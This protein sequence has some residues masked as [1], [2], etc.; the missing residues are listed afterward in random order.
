MERIICPRRR[1]CKCILFPHSLV[2]CNS[3]HNGQKEGNTITTEK[4][5][6]ARAKAINLLWLLKERSGSPGIHSTNV[7]KVLIDRIGV[8]ACVMSNGKIIF[9]EGVGFAGNSITSFC[10]C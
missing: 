6:Q 5:E 2:I 4:L 8:A 3:T 1:T 9:S 7:F 10:F